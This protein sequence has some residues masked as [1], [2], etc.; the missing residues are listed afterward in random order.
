M[1][2]KNLNCRKLANSFCNVGI[3]QII[4]N[5]DCRQN[6]QEGQDYHDHLQRIN[7]GSKLSDQR[8]ILGHVINVRKL[9]E[10]RCGIFDVFDV[11]IFNLTIVTLD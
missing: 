5:D 11:L 4:E 7:D 2:S 1:K 9:D 3:G 6:G 10:I 8:R